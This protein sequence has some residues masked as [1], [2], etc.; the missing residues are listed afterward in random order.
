MQY[1]I[2]K[3]RNELK[4]LFSNVK[5]SNTQGT[6]YKVSAKNAFRDI[7]GAT[8]EEFVVKAIEVAG[9]E[10]DAVNMSM[11]DNVSIMCRHEKDNIVPDDVITFWANY[12]IGG[13][14]MS[15]STQSTLRNM[16]RM[17]YKERGIDYK[18]IEYSIGRYNGTDKVA[19]MANNKFIR[20]QDEVEI[21]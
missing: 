13:S 2:N 14:G 12:Q 4:T 5:I 19:V 11:D 8:Y 1:I 16:A 17:I 10:V 20:F 6:L 15:T 21:A 7:H 9:F 18:T 3:L